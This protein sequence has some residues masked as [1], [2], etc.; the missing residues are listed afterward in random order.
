MRWIG[1]AVLHG[2][3][4]LVLLTLFLG[5]LV[6]ATWGW[7]T[8]APESFH[9]WFHWL[10]GSE[11]SVR[12]IE[13][14]KQWTHPEVTLNQF[15]L[16]HSDFQ[17]SAQKISLRLR[18][19][20]AQGSSLTVEQW[21]FVYTKKHHTRTLTF[22]EALTQL[23]AMYS[24]R[25][26]LPVSK[27]QMVQG[28]ISA[29]D[30]AVH[31][32]QLRW[33]Q[34]QA[35]KARALVKVLRQQA[36]LWTGRIE[37]TGWLDGFSRLKSGTLAVHTLQPILL[38]SFASPLNEPWQQ[39]K[40]KL[41]G[42]LRYQAGQ[43]QLS[44]DVQLDQLGLEARNGMRVHSLGAQLHWQ[45]VFEE[46]WRF[47]ITKGQLN[48][49]PFYLAAPLSLRLDDYAV[50]LSLKA[51]ELSSLQ[52]VL[53]LL[54]P[55]WPWHKTQFSM[56]DLQADFSIKPFRLRN[57]SGLVE[58]VS[59][60]AHMHHPGIVLEQI[61]V[62]TAVS[63]EVQ[64]H[65]GRP[66]LLSW[67]AWEH[68]SPVQLRFQSPL[69]LYRASQGGWG[70][71]EASF[72]LD[73]KMQGKL[74]AEGNL[75]QGRFSLSIRPGSLENIKA[76]LPYRS[77]SPK[78]ADWLKTSLVQGR[79]SPLSV[80]FD[81]PWQTL[82]DPDKSTLSAQAR[83][84]QG[85]LRFQPGWPALS[86]MDAEILF[87]PFD[88]EVKVA[89]ALMEGIQIG[90]AHAEITSLNQSDIALQIKGRAQGSGAQ[91]VSFLYHSPLG[92][93]LKITDLLE[94][95]EV[96]AGRVEAQIALWVPLYGY[97]ARQMAFDLKTEVKGLALHLPG[98][99]AV[100]HLT[101]QLHL[102][103]DYLAQGDFQGKLFEQPFSL[104]VDNHAQRAA[105]VLN[106][107]GKVPV[108]KYLAG[109]HG[110][111]HFKAQV[112][113]P[114]R[115]LQQGVS[116]TARLE[117]EIDGDTSA[118]PVLLQ[119][120]LAS[121]VQAQGQYEKAVLHF[122][123]AADRS[124]L[125]G[126][127]RLQEQVEMAYL[128]LLLHQPEAL[129]NQ[130]R[131]Y[132]A[133]GVVVIGALET[134]RLAPWLKWWSLQQSKLAWMSGTTYVALPKVNLAMKVGALH[135]AGQQFE[136]VV[137]TA[138]HLDD[139]RIGFNFTM[140]QGAVAGFYLPDN[141]QMIVSAERLKLRLPA[142][143]AQQDT[144]ESWQSRLSDFKLFFVGKSLQIGQYGFNDIRFNLYADPAQ[145]RLEN[146]QF[147]AHRQVVRGQGRFQWD[148]RS[149]QST[150][151]GQMQARRVERFLQWLGF[152]QTGF[153]GEKAVSHFS[154]NWQG[155]PNCFTLKNMQ[156]RV[157]FR[158]D[159]G[160]V[161]EVESGLA[162]IISLISVDSLLRNI[163]IT[164]KDL[165]YQGLVYDK[166]EGRAQLKDG[167]AALQKFYM[168]AP[169]VIVRMKGGIDLIRRRLDLNAKVTPKLMGSLTTL[170]AIFGLANPVT[171]VGTY[172][173]LKNV[174]GV[175]DEL[176]SYR[177]RVV[178]DW[179]A[180]K[181]IS[182]DKKAASLPQTTEEL[183][184]LQ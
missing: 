133:Q 172:I 143:Q 98:D 109:V 64:L 139:Q 104:K 40:L 129:V 173:F 3:K 102:D 2:L 175:R 75:V 176:V 11:V 134:L 91:A 69:V 138:F 80:H 168:D 85:I 128:N 149:Q 30:W 118:L 116:F 163:R 100:H 177:Y 117:H 22:Q 72:K 18:W 145:L 10:T 183:L 107:T 154:L 33:R 101:G 5:L 130:Y 148:Y 137:M 43:P 7:V 152:E 21:R 140:H 99:M 84:K 165:Q 73:E 78:L 113:I 24:P 8:Y 155:A 119:Q 66:I 144:C 157:T 93:R 146:I 170:A 61:Q 15:Q 37:L 178:G 180:P 76:Y 57:I 96:K 12:S 103:S 41:E 25:L 51:F 159:E 32:P 70:V 58:Q 19:R 123:V 184:E 95:I 131:R 88:L 156:G 42:A 81:G 162:K 13:W 16:R 48:G 53:A 169:S 74:H 150:I 68:D 59:L 45:A 52:P 35:L 124:I 94:H 121:P 44:L 153:T 171:A 39:G 46:D 114:L 86:E 164:L 38:K 83:L 161:E 92:A 82:L 132:P 141:N 122:T 90:S 28:E 31:I 182:M 89:H 106:S 34:Q 1:R 6:Q 47:F 49:Q 179:R 126:G 136:Q 4:A 9:K 14:Q 110:W 54:W 127:V 125:L 111:S 142:A 36:P 60:P 27:L 50:Q 65:L 17:F 23:K 174:P 105:I 112:D 115:D 62:Q 56:R 29:G 181:L 63:G 77:M 147:N 120:W 55:E 20:A 158:F 97:A 167:W 26:W 67:P 79:L 135:Y 166:I 108:E 87:K 160:V 71:R 151:T